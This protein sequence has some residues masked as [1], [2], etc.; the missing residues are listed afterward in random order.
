MRSQKVVAYVRCRH[1]FSVLGVRS[2]ALFKPHFANAQTQRTLTLMFHPLKNMRSHP[3]YESFFKPDLVWLR[4]HVPTPMHLQVSWRQ[5]RSMRGTLALSDINTTKLPLR[6]S[7]SLPRKQRASFPDFLPIPETL[8]LFKRFLFLRVKS[9]ISALDPGSSGQ[10]PTLRDGT[11]SRTVINLRSKR[12]RV[13]HHDDNCLS[14]W[15][16]P[17][18]LLVTIFIMSSAV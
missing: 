14:L 8:N 13:A 2:C 5:P 18:P 4:T 3:A 9:W 10:P 6:D 17:T 1:H 12:R 16:V 11:P 7:I 15:V